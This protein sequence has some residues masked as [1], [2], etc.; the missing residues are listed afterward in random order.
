[1]SMRVAIVW[2][3]PRAH[4]WQLGRREPAAY[5]DL[6]DGLLFLEDH[7]ITPVIENSCSRMLNP[8]VGYHEFYSGLDPIRAARVAVRAKRYDAIVCIGDATAFFLL[9]LKRWFGLRAPI[10][11]I[12]PALGDGYPRRKRLQD[13]V[14]PRV[15]RVIVYGTVQLAY[16]AREY[17]ERVRATFLHHRADT[18]FYRP[19]A[20]QLPPDNEPLIFS[21]GHDISRDFDTMAAAAAI[22]RSSGVRARFVV[23]TSRPVHDPSGTLTIGRGHLSYAALRDTYQRAS[24]VVLPLVN[25]R[26]AGGINALIEAMAS[27]AP[28]IASRSDGI[29][30][31]VQDEVTARLV[32]PSDPG[33]L[34]KAMTDLIAQPAFGRSLAA[35]ARRFVVDRCDNRRYAADLAVILR[36]VV[37]VADARRETGA[38]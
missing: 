12:D 15:D 38:R 26:H 5:P 14:L 32:A 33:A 2:P 3:K 16:L 10:V 9:H 11:L 36:D 37:R 25:S 1:M 17:G 13:F 20:P 21:V 19:A 27:G 23:Q 29:A 30:D 6:S 31:Y 28:L 18:D 35:E 8:L 22:V 34:A 24:V 7:D 4:R